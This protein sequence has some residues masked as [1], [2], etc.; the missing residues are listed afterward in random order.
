MPATYDPNL[1]EN[2]PTVPLEVME[3]LP[4]TMPTD[5]YQISTDTRQ[6]VQL[7]QWLKTDETDPALR[8]R[9]LILVYQNE[10]D[11]FFDTII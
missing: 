10:D 7:I 2:L 3:S 8:V 11:L 6:K 1:N 4:P 5:H 9:I